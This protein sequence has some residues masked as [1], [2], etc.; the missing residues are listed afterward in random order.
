MILHKFK[1]G[2]LLLTWILVAV[3]GGAVEYLLQF[4]EVKLDRERRLAAVEFANQLRARADRELNSVIYLMSGLSSYLTVRHRS[5]DPGELENMLAS[6]FATSRHVRNF[7]V[8]VG[9]RLTYV[10]PRNGNE[11]AVGLDYRS[12]PDQWPVVRRAV[13][14]RKAILTEQVELVQGGLGIIYRVPVYIDGQYWGLLS[15]V[16]DSDSF[17]NAAF[18]DAGNGLFEFALRGANGAGDLVWGRADIFADPQAVRV[19]SDN[20]WL[21]VVK[22]RG[23]DSQAVMCWLLRG[24]GWAF[25]LALGASAYLVLRHREDMAYL[26]LVDSLT[27]LP[28]RRLFSDRVE[29]VVARLGRHPENRCA[30]IFI[31]LDNFK[32]VNDKYGHRAG[33]TVLRAVAA[34]MRKCLNPGDTAGRWGGD[35]FVILAEDVGDDGLAALVER[36]RAT[37]SAPIGYGGELL[38]VSASIGWASGPGDA[39]TAEGLMETADGRMYQDRR[40]KRHVG[41][42][43]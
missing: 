36:L 7:G 39:V 12:Q 24:F 22:P 10:Y 1:H 14:G 16:L 15:T 28:S 18:R 41:E 19:E 2:S 6:L 29:Q 20:G 42:L 23:P 27:E 32:E 43:A 13:E 30:L 35:E 40:G 3:L 4:H 33:D 37:I 5:L 31:D 25:A 17:L 26:A 9:Y 34:R 38:R 8:A 21:F 11:K